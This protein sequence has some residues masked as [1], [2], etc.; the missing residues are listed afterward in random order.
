MKKKNLL[1]LLIPLFLLAFW[2]LS[3]QNDS[4]DISPTPT[5]TLTPIATNTAT[6]TLIPTQ[7]ATSTFT[8]TATPALSEVEGFTNTPTFTPTPTETLSWSHRDDDGDGV[9]NYADQCPQK[10]AET[11]NGCPKNNGGSGDPPEGPPITP[12]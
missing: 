9:L 1:L 11:D 3:T 6:L 7:T 4:D 5:N 12:H 2:I 8:P 10:Y